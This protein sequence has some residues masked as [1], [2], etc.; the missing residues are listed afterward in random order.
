MANYNNLYLATKLEKRLGIIGREREKRV[1]ERAIRS[2]EAEFIAL[3]GRRRVGKTF[4]VREYFSK[5]GTFL[6][7]S[8]LKDA[9]LSNQLENFIKSFSQ[10]FHKGVPLRIPKSWQEA[11]ELLTEQINIHLKSKK[12]IIFLDEFPWLATRKSGLI[13]AL[14]YFWNRFWSSYSNVILI[15]CG[16]AASWILEHLINAKGGL[17]NR[18]TRRI[19]L[20]PFS[21]KETQ[22]FLFSRKIRLN[23]KQIVDLYMCMGGVPYYL[24]E[25]ESGKSA[26][27]IID[28]LCFQKG[29]LLHTE[30]ENLF[31]SLFDHAELHFEIVKEIVKMGNKIS[32]KELIR[33]LKLSSGGGV[34]RRLE[35]LEASGFIQCFVPYGKKDRDRYYRLIDEYSLFYLKWIA[36]L[37]TSGTKMSLDYWKNLV[38][39]PKVSSWAGFAFE[40]VCLKHIHQIQ[41]ALKLEKIA[42]RTGAWRFVPKK[43]KMDEGAQIDLLFDREDGVVTLCEIKYSERPFRI[44]KSYAKK[45]LKKLEIFEEHFPI[46]KQLFFALITTM[47]LKKN[48]WSDEFIQ[49]TI[50]LKDLFK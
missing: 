4:L 33:A 40:N 27:Q 12:I 39:M 42:C 1:F 36:P 18:L 30:F 9:S 7:V 35:E 34:K 6:E 31:H 5:K 44:E 45:L 2:K 3:Y 11:F 26:T 15:V 24:K 29:G 19:L 38:K 43:E 37:R 10:T 25:I 17:H 46:K 41:K 47:G 8:G 22:K 14:D 23:Q 49:S 50:L 32:R 28:K 20:E 16:S 13:Q 21:L 48:A